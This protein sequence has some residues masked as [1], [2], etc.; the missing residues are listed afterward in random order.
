[1]LSLLLRQSGGVILRIVMIV[2][3]FLILTTS[4]VFYLQANQRNQEKQQ[5]KALQIA[6]SGLQA[7]LE[8]L[9]QDASWCAGF[10]KT[11][12]DNGWYLVR[13]TKS[14]AGDTLLV[15]IAAEGR[16][17]PVTRTKTCVLGRVWDGADSVWTKRNLY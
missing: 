14:A 11:P 7:A 15:N 16:F 8:K 5:R 6:E 10:S 3:T 12:C 9:N 1:L 4:I 2:V 17:G 13:I